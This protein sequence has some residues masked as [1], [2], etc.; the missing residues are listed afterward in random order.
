MNEVGLLLDLGNSQT[1]FAVVYK[2]ETEYFTYSNNY[3]LIQQGAKISSQYMNS[4]SSIFLYNEAL[5]AHGEIVA[6][7]YMAEVLRPSA[8][9]TKLEQ[10]STKLSL[11][12]V[13]IKTLEYL[14][15]VDNCAVDALDV[16]FRLMVLLPASEE[17]SQGDD[18]CKM[19]KEIKEV[20]QVAP[21]KLKT[22]VTIKNVAVFP[23]GMSA[24]VGVR[25]CE[26]NGAMVSK[27]E[28]FAKGYV[29]IVD[30]G[31]G[32]TNVTVVKDNAVIVA[33]KYTIKQ[34]ARAVF[35][36]TKQAISTAYGCRLNDNDEAFQIIET[37]MLELGNQN[38]P[39]EDIVSESK[40]KFARALVKEIE[41]YLE[42]ITVPIKALKGILFVGG[43]SLPS[44]R[45]GKVIS[46]A[47]TDIILE[48]LQELTATNG[49]ASTLELLDNNGVSARLLNLKGLEVIYKMKKGK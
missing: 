13:F 11:N 36:T 35:N 43:G 10:L 4:E 44:V 46:R 34:G 2:G 30:I 22:G 39:I 1:R 42:S 9:Q 17:E 18:F 33:S 6:N 26:E 5:Y 29:L 19:V 32:T 23:E 7:E 8:L 40:D 20:Q 37:C 45:G 27:N 25:F 49:N 16:A 38:I 47:I 41:S 31:G 3:A 15:K 14:A 12:F 28:K 24:F 21:K 48:Y